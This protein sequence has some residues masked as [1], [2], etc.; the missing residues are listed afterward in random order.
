MTIRTVV[1]HAMSANECAEIFAVNAQQDGMTDEFGSA[2]MNLDQFDN[3]ADVELL[4]QT[5]AA[6][7]DGTNAQAQRRGN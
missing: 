2:R 5:R 4:H 7:F 3:T 6:V 1:N